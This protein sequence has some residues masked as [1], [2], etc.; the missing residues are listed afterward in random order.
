MMW[1]EYGGSGSVRCRGD[2]PREEDA[3]IRHLNSANALLAPYERKEMAEPLSRITPGE[4]ASLP[5][6]ERLARGV[7]G[8]RYRRSG[9]GHP[10]VRALTYLITGEKAECT[11]CEA[12]ER[13][14]VDHIYPISLGGTHDAENLRILCGSCNSRKKNRTS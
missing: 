1:C 8:E 9:R 4:Y 5:I 11:L 13:L 14:T 12:T 3:W 7:A 10:A 2:S 6:D